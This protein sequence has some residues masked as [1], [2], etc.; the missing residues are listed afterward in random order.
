MEQGRYAYHHDG[1]HILHNMIIENEW[2]DVDLD[3]DYLFETANI[4]V[5]PDVQHSNMTVDSFSYDLS[6]LQDKSDHI[7]LRD[8]L[9]D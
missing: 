4:A 1:M 2:E 6:R 5:L 8:A 9:I 7:K 3:H